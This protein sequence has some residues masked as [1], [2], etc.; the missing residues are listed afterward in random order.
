MWDE[1]PKIT[2]FPSRNLKKYSR[3]GWHQEAYSN[4]RRLNRIKMFQELNHQDLLTKFLNVN[5]EF[6]WGSSKYEL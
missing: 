2:L 4:F 3:R 5:N 1:K 6:G